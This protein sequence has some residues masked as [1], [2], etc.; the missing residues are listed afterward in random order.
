MTMEHIKISIQKA[1]DLVAKRIFGINMKEAHDRGI[2]IRCKNPAADKMITE[3][4]QR[5]YKKSGLCE[6]CFA[7]IMRKIK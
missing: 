5:E 2:C 3:A 7:D 6:L 4:G 1:A